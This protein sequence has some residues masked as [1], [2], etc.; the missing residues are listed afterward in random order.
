MGPARRASPARGARRP[1]PS[2]A[3]RG[4]PAGAP[5]LSAPPPH[6][7][8]QSGPCAARSRGCPPRR[9][10]PWGPAGRAGSP[11][12]QTPG[13]T[14]GGPARSLSA[15]SR[16]P[17]DAGRAVKCR[18]QV[19]ARPA[20]G[21][22]AGRR[23]R[24]PAFFVSSWSL[25]V[26]QPPNL[27]LSPPN[28]TLGSRPTPSSPSPTR[29]ALPGAQSPA[30]GRPLRRGHGVREVRARPRRPAPRGAAAP[31]T[32][33]DAPPNFRGTGRSAPGS[34]MACARSG[35]GTRTG[36]RVA[37]WLELAFRRVVPRRLRR[38]LWCQ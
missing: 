6:F 9:A 29:P 36:P 25:Q 8:F 23:G 12:K 31:G 11:E 20:G 1:R 5:H 37:G 32:R 22:A 34:G 10:F 26:S 21:W 7:T 38:P 3:P 35:A 15:P 19:V 28:G 16:A 33:P 24:G 17:R 14:W 27:R 4:P 30:P 18:G 2:P 13:R